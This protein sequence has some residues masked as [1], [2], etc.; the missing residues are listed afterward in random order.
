[1]NDTLKEIRYPLVALFLL[2]LLTAF[3]LT[4]R[5]RLTAATLRVETLEVAKLLLASKP[6]EVAVEIVSSGGGYRAEQ[7]FQFRVPNQSKSAIEF[8]NTFGR[9]SATYICRIPLVTGGWLQVLID[10]MAPSDFAARLKEEIETSQD[11]AK[12][13]AD[14]YDTAKDPSYYQ[15]RRSTQRHSTARPDPVHST[16]KS[17]SEHAHVLASPAAAPVPPPAAAPVP[18]SAASLLFYAELAIDS[19]GGKPRA[20]LEPSG[21]FVVTNVERVAEEWDTLTQGSHTNY[22]PGT[23]TVY[24]PS[25]PGNQSPSSDT[26][27]RSMSSGTADHWEGP[28]SAVTG[29]TPGSW[30]SPFVPSG[31]P[32]SGIAR[33]RPSRFFCSQRFISS[34]FSR[35]RPSACCYGARANLITTG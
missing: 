35:L 29:V 11:W 5:Q 1:M 27:N 32:E 30:S 28:P 8:L 10:N 21:R 9:C 6:D 22:K 26:A 20:T 18:I 17:G 4:E 23:L 34:P 24:I 7:G 25:S 14:R 2:A 31:R 33:S 19:P 16:P 15:F 3:T 12:V 13:R